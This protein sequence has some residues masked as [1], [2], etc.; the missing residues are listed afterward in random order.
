MPSGGA[1]VHLRQRVVEGEG[2]GLNGRI[3]LEGRG[4]LGSDG[5]RAASLTIN[6]TMDKLKE[7][8]GY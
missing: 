4:P 1:L 6:Q 5:Q 3:I 8:I 7:G 2:V